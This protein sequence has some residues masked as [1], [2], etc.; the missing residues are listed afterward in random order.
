MQ[1]IRYKIIIIYWLLQVACYFEIGF[2]S[3]EN[4]TLIDMENIFILMDLSINKQ[5]FRFICN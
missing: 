3:E 2:S 5:P 4:V 1:F